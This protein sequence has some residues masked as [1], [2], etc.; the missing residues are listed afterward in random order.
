MSLGPT[1]WRLRHNDNDTPDPKGKMPAWQMV[2]AD[3]GY[4]TEHPA[5]REQLRVAI[6][7]SVGTG[8]LLHHDTC[9]KHSLRAGCENA[10]RWEGGRRQ[11]SSQMP[12]CNGQDRVKVCQGKLR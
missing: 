6:T 3:Q 1:L 4:S 9:S 11:R 5:Y 12:G 2:G 7:S 8:E 10:S